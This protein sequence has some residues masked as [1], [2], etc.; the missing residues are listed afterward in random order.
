MRWRYL[1]G[2]GPARTPGHLVAGVQG[3]LDQL[4][5]DPGHP[6]QVAGVLG[7]RTQERGPDRRLPVD[8]DQGLPG[9]LPRQRR[10]GLGRDRGRRSQVAG[11]RGCRHGRRPARAHAWDATGEGAADPWGVHLVLGALQGADHP[12]QP[13]EPGP[14]SQAC[15]RGVRAR[16]AQGTT[17]RP[18]R[19][20]QQ[21]HHQH[22]NATHP[23]PTTTPPKRLASRTWPL[24]LWVV[25]AQVASGGQLTFPPPAP[26][27]RNGRPDTKCLKRKRN[28]LAPTPN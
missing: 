7:V 27:N 12:P 11:R 20:Q 21:D 25:G 16:S 1:G 2:L 6:H 22:T 19:P 8:T 5:V 3:H 10:L 14:L 9:A 28:S 13:V 18:G 17:Y 15:A 4:L 23:D 26:S 24:L